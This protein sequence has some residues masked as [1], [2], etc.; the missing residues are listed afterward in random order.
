M[1]YQSEACCF[2]V[3]E[4]SL[5]FLYLSIRQRI[6]H[7]LVWLVLIA[8]KGISTELIAGAPAIETSK[9]AI[10]IPCPKR[11]TCYSASFIRHIDGGNTGYT[12][13]LEQVLL[14]LLKER[15]LAFWA[16]CIPSWI[17][18]TILIVYDDESYATATTNLPIQCW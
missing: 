3:G 1:G 9:Q 17:R 12:M 15:C 16:R 14:K 7:V 18:P 2:S 4:W 6:I 8:V 13:E 11:H 5:D 10:E